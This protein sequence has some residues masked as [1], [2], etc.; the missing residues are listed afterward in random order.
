[1]NAPLAIWAFQSLLGLHPPKSDGNAQLSRVLILSWGFWAKM[2]FFSLLQ[3]VFSYLTFWP[4]EIAVAGG[5][6]I[7]GV[8]LKKSYGLF[9]STS[10][11]LE[12]VSKE[13][14]YFAA[15]LHLYAGGGFEFY[16]VKKKI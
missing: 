3:E 15:I 11:E 8:A 5:T 14:N 2:H 12:L 7:I 9:L 1:M 10:L 13:L 4:I 16:R 6:F